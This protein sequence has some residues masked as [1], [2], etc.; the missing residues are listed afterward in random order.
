MIFIVVA[1][2]R[3]KL[4][5]FGCRRRKDDDHAGVRMRADILADCLINHNRLN[6]LVDRAVTSVYRALC[7]FEIFAYR[8]GTRD[9]Q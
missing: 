1:R 3:T 7:P 9:E 4:P 6:G 5:G 8:Q 2:R